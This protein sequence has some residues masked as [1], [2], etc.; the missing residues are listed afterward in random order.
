MTR[1]FLRAIAGAA[2]TVLMAGCATQTDALLERRIGALLPADVILLGEQ[3]DADAHRDVQRAFVHA[4]A[5]RGQL[6]ALVIEMADRGRSTAGLPHD[7]SA[8]QVQ[9]SLHWDDSG[10]PWARYAPVIMAAVRSGVPVLGG[11]LP[12][13]ELRQSMNETGLDRHLD[14]PALAR[15]REAIRVGHCD[16]LPA[17]RLMPM[18]RVQLARDASMARTAMEAGAPGKTVLLVAGG[19]HVLRDIGIPTHLS[20]SLRVRTVLAVA[21]TRAADM[22]AD[23]DLVWETPAVPPRDHCAQLR[24]QFGG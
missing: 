14:G 12:R 18:V 6:A 15:Q 13:A 20:R 2:L 21:G 5:E 11:N 1:R 8:A 9:A 22:D 17:A 3:H 4:L 19:G 16:L 7:A 23:A 10:W 24:K